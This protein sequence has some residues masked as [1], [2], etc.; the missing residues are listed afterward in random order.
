MIRWSQKNLNQLRQHQLSAL[1][2]G[3]AWLLLL[4][5]LPTAPR[6][7]ALITELLLLAVLVFVPLALGLA[8]GSTTP[9][10]RVAGG[11]RLALRVQPFAAAAVAVAFLLPAGRLAGALASSWLL[12]TSIAALLGV[13]RLFDH[14]IRDAAELCIDVSLM[15]LPVGGFWLAMARFGARPLAFGDTIVLL[16]AV[17]FHY[18]GFALL[19]LAGLAG[20]RL[21]AG[22]S[23]ARNSFRLV[24]AGMIAGVPLVALGITFSRRLEILAVLL[25][26]S[27]VLAFALLTLLAVLP[28][29]ACRAARVL[30]ALSALA[31]VATMLLAVGYAGGG[32]VG[33]ALTIPQMVV[34]HGAVNT[35]GLVLCGLLAWTIEL[36]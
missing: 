30:L 12:F 17:H 21:R 6:T 2:G 22:A 29:L 34:A 23:V 8:A 9:T 16:T 18:A 36:S 4:A 27:S 5:L 1:I 13:A 25:L 7:I 32:F 3:L 14:G 15:L 35:F 19:L 20:R 10:R 26:T 33:L 28:L 11:W 31:S 24:A